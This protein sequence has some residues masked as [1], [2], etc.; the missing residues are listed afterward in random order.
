MLIGQTRCVSILYANDMKAGAGGWKHDSI[1]VSLLR[2]GSDLRDIYLAKTHF[3]AA[4]IKLY[5][6]HP[7][8]LGLFLFIMLIISVMMIYPG[9]RLWR[10]LFCV[11]DN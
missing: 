4:V 6:L 3:G 11:A 10:T 8:M 9:Y 5:K 2:W 7:L 1:G